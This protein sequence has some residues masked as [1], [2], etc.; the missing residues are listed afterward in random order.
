V[1]LT[2]T[3]DILPFLSDFPDIFFPS[4]KIGI[5]IFDLFTKDVANSF[6]L[7]VSLSY[8]MS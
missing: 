1:P 7:L 8:V 2:T 3:I 6:D 5:D 4:T